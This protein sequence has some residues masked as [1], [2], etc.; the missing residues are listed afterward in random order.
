MKTYRREEV[1]QRVL[2]SCTCDRCKKEYDDIMEIQEFLHYI[3]DAGYSSVF[4]DGNMLDLDLCQ[5]CVKEVLGPFIRTVG[6]YIWNAEQKESGSLR[7]NELSPET[8]TAIKTATVDS[9]HNHLNELMD[10]E[11]I[12]AKSSSF[13]DD[14]PE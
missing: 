6:N 4:G 12:F 11:D 14:K 13:K 8:S 10:E 9:K 3:N 5:Y 1:F 2:V 7:I